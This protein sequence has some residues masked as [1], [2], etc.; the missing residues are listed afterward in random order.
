MAILRA[1][2]LCVAEG[3][4]PVRLRKI[5]APPSGF[6]I[7]NSVAAMKTVVFSTSA[8]ENCMAHPCPYDAPGPCLRRK[9]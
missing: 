5:G 2:C 4:C 9:C 3:Y 6:T 1:N 7:G 8:T